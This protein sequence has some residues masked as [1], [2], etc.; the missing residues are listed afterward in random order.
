MQGKW[1]NGA[2]KLQRAQYDVQIA[3]HRLNFAAQARQVAQGRL[4]YANA[5][6]YAAE[7]VENTTKEYKD[8]V[9][10]YEKSAKKNSAEAEK[11]MNA[12][13]AKKKKSE[14]AWKTANGK[15]QST[16]MK[17]YV[18]FRARPADAFVDRQPNPP[19]PFAR[20]SS[21]QS[22]TRLPVRLPWLP[23][24]MATAW[25]ALPRAC[26]AQWVLLAAVILA[27]A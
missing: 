2:S 4:Y 26:L 10:S 11:T 13:L 6:I 14:A 3:F 5:V 20:V 1:E 9:A 7:S 23:T 27:M 22:S 18:R 25:A 16:T 21:S 12:A 17:Q 19:L 8:T 24:C 15:V